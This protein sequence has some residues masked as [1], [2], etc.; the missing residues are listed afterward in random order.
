MPHSTVWQQSLSTLYDDQK[1]NAII[2]RAQTYYTETC[3]QHSGEAKRAN[4]TALKTRVLPGLS[5]YKALLE[6]N[7]D[8]KKVLEEVNTLFR[9]A[10]F[11]RRMQGI[12][13]LNHWPDPFPIVKPVL[14]MMTRDEYLPGSQEIVED[15][16]ECYAINVYRCFILDTLTR[17]DAKELTA[18]FCNTDDWL[19]EALPKIRWERTKTLGRGDERCDF[20][21]CR[22]KKP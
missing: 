20:R 21:W 5:I 17:H 22:I 8:P 14:R 9:A 11:P 18:L 16:A 19:A 13:V 12:R 4:R 10:F 2:T 1:V 6:E 15:N 3:L 7:D